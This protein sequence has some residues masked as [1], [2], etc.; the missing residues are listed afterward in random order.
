MHDFRTRKTAAA[1]LQMSARE[2]IGGQPRPVLERLEQEAAETEAAWQEA[3]GA[4]ER[5]QNVYRTN[6]G[7]A[8]ALKAQMEK[9]CIRDRPSPD[10]N[11]WYTS[12][13]P[14]IPG[15]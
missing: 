7:A 8:E 12:R 14:G 2:A 4:R 1:Q 3:Q 10:R 13:S 15:C 5:L 9:M 11:Q 6:Q